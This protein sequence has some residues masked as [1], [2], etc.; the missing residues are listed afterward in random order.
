[1]ILGRR[2]V[3]HLL[4]FGFVVLGSK[5]LRGA[6]LIFCLRS[7]DTQAIVGILR[8]EWMEGRCLKVIILSCLDDYIKLR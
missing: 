8:D 5:R 7:M 2:F 3:D 6:V 4:V 1:M